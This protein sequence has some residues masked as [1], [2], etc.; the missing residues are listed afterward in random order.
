M[1]RRRARDPLRQRLEP[2]HGWRDSPPDLSTH[3]NDGMTTMIS[4]A[5]HDVHLRLS[6]I[7]GSLRDEALAAK[8]SAYDW[9]VSDDDFLMSFRSACLF[10][11]VEDVEGARA[12]ILAC[13]AREVRRYWEARKE[14]RPYQ[15]TP[16]TRPVEPMPVKWADEFAHLRKKGEIE[17]IWS[18]KPRLPRSEQLPV[19]DVEV[20]DTSPA[21]G[22]RSLPCP[23]PP[24]PE[25]DGEIID[26]VEYLKVEFGQK[27]RTA[28]SCIA[29]WEDAGA[30]YAGQEDE[31]A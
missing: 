18:K 12:F 13:P 14:G 21:T 23:A 28:P 25:L 31:D 20:Q 2:L 1:G 3:E 30:S 10:V 4:Q 26:L 27:D 22:P 5:W 15:L 8:L 9:L 11:G 6:D 17:R 7:P 19:I 29:N 16:A 24:C